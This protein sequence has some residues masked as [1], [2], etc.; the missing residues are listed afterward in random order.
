MKFADNIAQ[1]L[2]LIIDQSNSK[3]ALT[4]KVVV[5]AIH[6]FSFPSISFHSFTAC[7]DTFQFYPTV[8]VDEALNARKFGFQ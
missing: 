1:A 4:E 5:A 8:R 6:S 3:R 7:Y 2:N